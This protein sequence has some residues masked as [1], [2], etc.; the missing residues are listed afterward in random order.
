MTTAAC[1]E[2][3]TRNTAY[4]RAAF[5]AR[6]KAGLYTNWIQYVTHTVYDEKGAWT[7]IPGEKAVF[8]NPHTEQEHIDTFVAQLH[9][10]TSI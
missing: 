9:G 6:G 10:A 5:L 2:R 8:F 3:L 1:R 7:P 4:H